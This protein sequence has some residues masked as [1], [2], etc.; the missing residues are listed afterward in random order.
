MLSGLDLWAYAMGYIDE[1]DIGEA[2]P[3]PGEQTIVAVK[4]TEEKAKPRV[5]L[6][7]DEKAR[8]KA[9]LNN[10]RKS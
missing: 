1:E 4:L 8:H 6:T 2:G 5:K 3:P 10:R 9:W 7:E